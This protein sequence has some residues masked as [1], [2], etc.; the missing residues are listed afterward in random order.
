MI[1]IYKKIY[2][3]EETQTIIIKD[4]DERDVYKTDDNVELE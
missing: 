2:W 3:D 4:L 1:D